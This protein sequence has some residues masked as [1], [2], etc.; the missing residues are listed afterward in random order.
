MNAKQKTAIVSPVVIIGM[1]VPIF[2][3]LGN[4]LGNSVG[5]YLGL[6]IYWIIWG[7]VFPWIMIG[8]DSIVRLIRPQKLSLKLLA[9]V[10]FPVLMAAVFRFSTGME[11]EKPALWFLFILVSTNLGNGFFEEVLWRGMY[12][13]L[14]P[15]RVI[16]RIVW[17]TVWFALW[18]YAPGSISASGN[19]I[20]LMIGSGMMGLYFAFL[21]HKTGTIWWTM[22]AHALGGLIMVI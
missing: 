22:I 19:P 18:H 21:A 5:W 1:M 13:E 2:R 12:L 14:F 8:K 9:M 6:W 7:G 11:Y 17:S 16:F 20:G 15:N 4:Q 3:F 10:A